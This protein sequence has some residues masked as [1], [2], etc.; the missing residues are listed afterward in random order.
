MESGKN[1]TCIIIDDEINAIDVIEHYLDDYPNI[2][3]AGRFTNAIEAHN[4][5]K[6]NQVDLIFLDIQMPGISGIDFLRSLKNAPPTFLTTAYRHYGPEAFDL[7]VLDYLLKPI[8]E[9]RFRKAIEKFENHIRINENNGNAGSGTII[10]RAN[11]SNIKLKFDDILYLESQGDYIRIYLKEKRLLTKQTLKKIS[12][13]LPSSFL[14]VH[15]SF[16]VNSMHIDEE[17]STRIRINDDI[18]PVSR[19]FRQ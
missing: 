13:K 16:I 10:I 6:I 5:I 17:S 4:W 14:H 12:T 7:N 11:R 19:K 2:D 1:K 3:V 9:N 18:I 8:S 15:R